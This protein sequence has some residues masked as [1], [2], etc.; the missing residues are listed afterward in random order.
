M[1]QSFL[2]FNAQIVPLE[3]SNLIEASAGTGKTYSIAILVLRLVVEK[4]FPVSGILM[5]TFTKAAVAE[6]Q[7]RIR[8]FIRQA[9]RASNEERIADAKI[10]GIVNAAK[11][12]YGDEL[13]RGRLRDAVL[14]LD[15]TPVL[16]IHSFCQQ[17]LN[18]F[19]FETAQL[20]GAEMLPDPKALIQSGLDD[21][22][23]RHVTTLPLELLSSI[24]TDKLR[25]EWLQALKEHLGGKIYFGYDAETDYQSDEAAMK[26]LLES[27]RVAAAVVQERHDE[28]ARYIRE[29]HAALAGVTA[30]N[31]FAVKSFGPELKRPDGFIKVLR[32]KKE[33]GYVV[34]IYPEPLR[35][36]AEL[37]L[38]E[39]GLNLLQRDWRLRLSFLAIQEVSR[40]LQERKQRSNLLGYD[41][42]IQNLHRALVLRE[43]PRL[44]EALQKKYPAVFID[45]FQDTDREQYEIF[46]TAFEGGSILFYIGDPKQSIYAF[47]K[48]DIFTYFMAR[49]GVDK[50]YGMNQNFRSGEQLIHAMNRFFLPK[51]GFDTFAFGKAE[52]AIDYIPVESP[53]PNSKGVFRHAGEAEAPLTVFECSNLEACA[54]AAADQISALLGGD[55]TIL[56]KAREERIKPSD[57]GV[58]VRRAF[59]GVQVKKAL[60]LMGI[61][62]V[63][64]DESKVLQTDEAKAVLRILQAAAQPDRSAINRALLAPFTGLQIDDLLRLDDEAALRYFTRYRDRWQRDGLYTAVM[65]FFGDF[66]VQQRLSEGRVPGAERVLSNLLQVTELVHE[67]QSRKAL[68][69]AETLAWLERAISGM[70]VEGDAY[71]QRVESD[72][73]AVRIVTIHR[74]KGLEYPIVIAPFLDFVP[75]RNQDFFSFRDPETGRYYGIEGFRITAEQQALH[76]E[77]EEQENRRLLY[78]AIT[79]AVHACYIFRNTKSKISTLQLFLD[80]LRNADPDLIHFAEG[81]PDAASGR[82]HLER[83]DALRPTRHSPFRL[84]QPDWRRLSY[85]GLAGIGAIHRFGRAR[86]SEEEYDR[87]IFL[88]LSRGRVTGELVHY[89][90]ERASFQ[91]QDRWEHVIESAIRRFAPGKKEAYQPMLRRMLEQIVAAPISIGGRTFQL[92]DVNWR[93]RISEFEFDFPVPSFR[94]ERLQ[95]L[96]SEDAT[97]RLKDSLPD[98]EGMMNGKIDL[99]FGHEGRFYI[100]DWK[101]N[102]LGDSVEDY[103]STQLKAAMNAESYHLQYL[104]YTVAAVKYLRSR[105]PGFSYEQHFGGVVYLFLRGVRA[106]NESGLFTAR[107]AEEFLRRLEQLLSP[108]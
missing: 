14:F 41:D 72:E 16:T 101:T 92:Q 60:G 1:S 12:A 59:E 44:V 31:R 76:R 8:L 24:W 102:Y 91:E 9:E 33:T 79:R 89:I 3:G 4:G 30:A 19:A 64:I 50:R 13:V 69:N 68:S 70:D 105:I 97:F 83:R 54:S 36:L 98:A 74:S 65:S 6:L 32:E 23:R 27:L 11:A 52:D 46:R 90:L 58:L 56:K 66:Q 81:P 51:P 21:F 85:T 94:L 34:K 82:F 40:H 22:W 17:T 43:N 100:L 80:E 87:F 18:E 86:G 15:E 63:S 104:I 2:P 25:A 95:E 49:S 38:A 77:Q 5:V 67:L 57:I 26:A 106:G 28:L 53:Q 29:N 55:Y 35:L 42:M 108:V 47:R 39:A 37:E 7:D 61:P 103:S 96:S 20:F 73:E 48:A 62:A 99:F 71:E 45:E 10:A 88:E 75:R 84:V 78:V 107:P 93:N